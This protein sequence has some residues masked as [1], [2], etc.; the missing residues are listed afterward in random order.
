MPYDAL[1]VQSVAK[2]LCQVCNAALTY[3]CDITLLLGVL[4]PCSS[5]SVP[6]TWCHAGSTR[7]ASPQHCLAGWQARQHPVLWG[8]RRRGTS[9]H[10]L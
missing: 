5:A 9:H 4:A 7:P 3:L 8:V 10:N 6:Q 2:Q 1:W